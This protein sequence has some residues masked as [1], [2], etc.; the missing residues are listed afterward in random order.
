MALDLT[1]KTALITGGAGGIG[2]ATAK[3]FIDHGARVAITDI[4]RTESVAQLDVL[5]IEC[6]VS[7]EQQVAAVFATAEKQLG[8]LDIIV[9]NAGLTD[10]SGSLAEMEA[11]YFTRM[12]NVNV[13]GVFYGLKHGPK[14][15]N[16]G[17]SVIN[18]ASLAA[19][20]HMP[21]AAAYH[22]T[23][24]A[25]VSLTKSAALELGG[26]DIRVNAVCPGHTWVDRPGLTK[27]SFAAEV[28]QTETL[29]A[30]GR[31]GQVDE[32]AGVFHFLAA[33]ESQYIT[34]QAL[35][36]DGGFSLGLTYKAF[37]KLGA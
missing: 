25:V 15:M 8:K 16:D 20:L 18:T 2:W 37:D 36:V 9:N 10:L 4:R 34:G 6:D 35:V 22:A 32:Q 31:M 7:D 11:S 28:A 3:R 29:T 5:F 30:L 14:H 27:E 12:H 17:G 23:K 24:A 19:F 13:D 1:G 21:G 33:D 26:R